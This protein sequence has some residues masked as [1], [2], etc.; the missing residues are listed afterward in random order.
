MSETTV[1]SIAIQARADDLKKSAENIKK[2]TTDMQTTITNLK[3]S[4]QGR[5]AEATIN[6][7]NQLSD[8]FAAIITTIETYSTIL[9][10]AAKLYKDIE[11]QILNGAQGDGNQ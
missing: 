1:R 11:L 4:W 10:Q 9:E 7:F 8:D 3:S 5:A 2:Y 6:R